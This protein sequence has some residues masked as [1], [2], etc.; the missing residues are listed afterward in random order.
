VQSSKH[1]V[2]LHGL[3]RGVQPTGVDT[4]ID[5]AGAAEASFYP[6][7][8]SKD[9]L[10]TASL[11]ERWRLPLIGPPLARGNGGLTRPLSVGASV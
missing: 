11:E 2:L 1:G 8:P 3:R 5:A 7:L 10:V 6:H 9:D 4:I